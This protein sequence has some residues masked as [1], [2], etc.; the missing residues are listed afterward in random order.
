MHSIKVPRRDPKSP[1]EARINWRNSR[2]AARLLQARGDRNARLKGINPRARAL[3]PPVVA[4]R[5]KDQVIK[6]AHPERQFSLMRG[7]YPAPTPARPTP[8]PTWPSSLSLF[9]ASSLA[10]SLLPAGILSTSVGSKSPWI[11]VSL[12]RNPSS[13]S[14]S[15]RCS[16]NSSKKNQRKT[17]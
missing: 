11:L 16:L 15:C 13:P 10:P 2:R 6:E 3:V 1:R 14:F 9:A 5:R 7:S 12:I 4:A 17:F 8:F